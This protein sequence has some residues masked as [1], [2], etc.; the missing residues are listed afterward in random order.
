MRA[1]LNRSYS[2][3]CADPAALTEEESGITAGPSSSKP[4]KGATSKPVLLKDYQRARMIADPTLSI[5]DETPDPSF[6][7]TFAQEERALKEE[8]TKAFGAGAADSDEEDDGL[9]V[10]RSK[11]KD[12]RQQEEEDYAKFLKENAGDRAVEDALEAEEKFLRE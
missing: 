3:G 10:R 2:Y 1:R 9:L 12:E 6:R 7:P 4:E 5:S 8:V 11:T